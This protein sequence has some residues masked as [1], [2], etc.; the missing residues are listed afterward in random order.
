[1]RPEL[2]T[3]RSSEA[4]IATLNKARDSYN[5]DILAQVA[6][7]AAVQDQAYARQTWEAVRAERARLTAALRQRSFAVPDSHSNFV[8]VGVPASTGA[9]ASQI[10]KHLKARNILIR[11][12]STPGLEDKLRITVGTPDQNTALLEAI[13]SV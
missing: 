6:A 11:Y 9:S 12:F 1:M 5:T 13:D 2:T 7:A 4:L 3:E 10:Y 8:L